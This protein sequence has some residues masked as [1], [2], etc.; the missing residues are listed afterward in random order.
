MEDDLSSVAVPDWVDWVARDANG[1]LWGFSVEPLIG[2][3]AW[4]E[5]EVGRYIRLADGPPDPDWQGSLRRHR[6]N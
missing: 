1:A 6:G 3:R 2:D 4:Y 5:N